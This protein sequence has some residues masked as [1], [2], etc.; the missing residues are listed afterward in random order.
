MKQMRNNVIELLAR[1]ARRTNRKRIPI[2]TA[3]AEMQV[4]YYTLNAIVGNT[5]REY[6]V[7]ALKKLCDYL[8][9]NVGDILSY[10][11]APTETE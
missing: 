3:A 8:D 11:E 5:I 2:K 4:S 7:D 10:E 1:Q 9:C 6:P